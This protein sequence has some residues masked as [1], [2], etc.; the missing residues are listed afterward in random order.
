MTSPGLPL[1]LFGQHDPA[2]VPHP[3]RVRRLHL[4]DSSWVDHCDH[5]IDGADTLLDSLLESLD[6]TQAQRLMFGKWL[7]EP[8][9]TG[10]EPRSGATLPPIIGAIRNWLTSHYGKTFT[11]LFCN[12]YRS[13]EDSVAWHSDRIGRAAVE[14]LVAIVSLGGPRRLHLRPKGGGTSHRVILSSGS[15]L[16]MGGAT[17]HDW[18]HCVPKQR[19]GHPRISVTM[20]AGWLRSSAAAAGGERLAANQ[21]DLLAPGRHELG[22]APGLRRPVP[23]TVRPV[24]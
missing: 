4:D 9:L 2:L 18:E 24:P 7:I 17:Q 3:A 5:L 10:L 14:P 8:R 16:V 6:W 1:T 23:R 15:L 22:G 12:Y 13:G 21:T 11:G 19:H 20:R